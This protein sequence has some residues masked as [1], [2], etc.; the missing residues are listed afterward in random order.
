M[1]KS[2]EANPNYSKF[3]E[4]VRKAN[5]TH[6]LTNE[7]DSF[8]LLVPK[9]DVFDELSESSESKATAQSQA[10]LMAL[11]KTLRFWMLI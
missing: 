1:L 3:L 9:N 5:L 8:T 6:L 7:S 11:V 10:E 2:L 4:L